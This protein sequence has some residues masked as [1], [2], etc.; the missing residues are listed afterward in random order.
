MGAPRSRSA[1]ERNIEVLAS[2][3]DED[4]CPSPDWRGISRGPLQQERKLDFSKETR[5]G[6]LGLHRNLRGTLSFLPQLEKTQEILPSTRDEALFCCS[7]RREILASL[8]SL[9]RL[10]ETL[11]TTQEV[12]RH[13]HLHL[14]RTLSFLPPLK[15][16]PIFPSSSRVG[17][18]PFRQLKGAQR[19]PSSLEMKHEIP[20]TTR[21]ESRGSHLI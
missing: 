14:R 13:T 6:P 4:I 3:P 19:S 12:P 8:L 11:Y 7:I 21:G 9:E 17:L 1:L 20:T 16:S 5:V 10:L 2:S 18:T 15:K